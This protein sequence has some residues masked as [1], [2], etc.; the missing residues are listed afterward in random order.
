MLHVTCHRQAHGRYGK[1]LKPLT[2]A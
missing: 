2:A 1:Q